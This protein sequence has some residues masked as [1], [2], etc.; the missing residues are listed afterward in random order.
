MRI[1]L[2]LL[3][4]LLFTKLSAQYYE[5][6]DTTN[7]QTLKSTLH[8]IIDS[9]TM[10]PYTS[11][12]RDT[13]DV[14]YL[15]D[16]D[17]FNP[18]NIWT[19]YKNASYEWLGGGIQVYNR[20]HTWPQSYG[21]DDDVLGDNNPARTDMHALM[22]ADGSYNNGRGNKFYDDCDS[23]CTERPTDMINGQGGGTGIYPGNSNWFDIDS[24]EVWDFKPLI[25]NDRF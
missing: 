8:N 14:L 17:P 16:Q 24:Y 18:D 1:L 5:D 13:W 12:D 9:H 11:Q 23:S 10:F 2:I 6:V 15:A 7:S 20:E 22:L 19:I 21:F 3:L 4:V 25:K